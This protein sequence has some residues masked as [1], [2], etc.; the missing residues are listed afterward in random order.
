MLSN[1]PNFTDSNLIVGIDHSDDAAVYKIN[2][3]Q[4]LVQSVDI[5]PPV[6]DDPYDYGAIAAA[7][8]LSDIYAMGG[9]PTLV[10]NI[11]C[12]P[13]D[14]D[15]DVIEEILRGGHD[16]IAEAGA[17]VGGGHSI[18]DK[19]P[20]YGLCVTGFVQPNALLKNSTA[21]PGDALIVTKP[22]GTGILNTAA[23]AGL[24]GADAQAE[25]VK[26]MSMLNK[27]AAEVMKQ[28]RVHGCTDITGFGLLG[29]AFEMAKGSGTTISLD[30]NSVPLL[31]EVKKMARMGINPKGLYA[32]RKWL[33][34]EVKRQREIPLEV[35]DIL[36]DPQTS[37]GLLISLDAGDA[38]QCLKALQE[39]IPHARIVG[40]VQEYNECPIQIR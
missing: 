24:I 32:N 7:N 30:S 6:V 26:Q 33:A 21:C 28:Y 34:N 35:E 4:Y 2:E 40:E 17:V 37:G 22:L 8:S 11:L 10:L 9:V 38:K 19:E 18:K 12:L 36:Y 13:E 15:Q 25:L 27:T 23:K 1:I 31:P 14:M 16:K 20:K 3:E 29:H 5:F 39:T